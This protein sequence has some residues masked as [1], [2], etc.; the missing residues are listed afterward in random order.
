[1]VINFLILWV[2]IKHSVFLLSHLVRVQRIPRD[3]FSRLAMS[4][5][6][7]RGRDGGRGR[8]R[9]KDKKEGKEAGRQR[10]KGRKEK[11]WRNLLHVTVTCE[12]TCKDP[13]HAYMHTH[14]WMS[15]V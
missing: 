7:R 14:K 5:Q 3:S 8:E 9:E 11:S 6:K 1:M 4:E 2:G 15:R 13:S 10:K 12:V